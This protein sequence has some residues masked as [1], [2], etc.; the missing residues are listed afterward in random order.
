LLQRKQRL[1]LAD[2][3]LFEFD[4]GV[5]VRRAQLLATPIA[6]PT[7]RA[8]ASPAGGLEKTSAVA[9][10]TNPVTSWLESHV[11]ALPLGLAILLGLGLGAQLIT[12]RP[13]PL[14]CP[15][16]NRQA[17][18]RFGLLPPTA[19]SDTV[20]AAGTYMVAAALARGGGD[21]DGKEG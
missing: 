20:T 1:Q 6:T 2:H 17:G 19:G 11:V 9:R 16:T 14:T 15:G 12:A 3:D 21:P 13:P 10:D 18:E 8:S 4:R 7:S 5:Q